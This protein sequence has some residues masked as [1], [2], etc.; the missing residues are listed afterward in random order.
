MKQSQWDEVIAL[1][2]TGVFLCTQ[3]CIPAI[4]LKFWYSDFQGLIL[5]Y[6]L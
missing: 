2:L 4:L 6:S 1:N 5:V 3:V